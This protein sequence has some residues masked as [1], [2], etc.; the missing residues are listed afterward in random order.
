MKFT[1][2]LNSTI[3]FVIIL[4]SFFT[5]NSCFTG[6]FTEETPNGTDISGLP[7]KYFICDSLDVTP[8][9][10]TLTWKPKENDSVLI[11]LSGG[12]CSMVEMESGWLKDEVIQMNVDAKQAAGFS[13]VMMFGLSSSQE[14]RFHCNFSLEGKHLLDHD[15]IVYKKEG[16]AI[17]KRLV[18][19]YLPIHKIH[20]FRSLCDK[21]KL[22]WDHPIADMFISPEY[23]D[24]LETEK[25][26]DIT[27]YFTLSLESCNAN[28]SFFD[29]S[30][31]TKVGN[32]VTARANDFRKYQVVL[33]EPYNLEIDDTIF[34]LVETDD[35]ISK[36]KMVVAGTCAIN[37]TIKNIIVKFDKN[38]INDGDTLSA[39]IYHTDKNGNCVRF[40][41]TTR[42]EAGIMIGCNF[43]DIL[44]PNG[45]LKKYFNNIRQPI[46]IVAMDP[47]PK[48]ETNLRLRVGLIP[49]WENPY[50]PDN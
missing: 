37:D 50:N 48:G 31:N 11:E 2:K 45:Q 47:I 18:R 8:V 17:A 5:L 6:M 42:F 4:I 12:I 35:F 36:H 29:K 16:E 21:I 1:R 49:D 46:K 20:K 33:N 39:Y 40:A 10:F 30:L 25:A 14:Y 43:A 38:S 19:V 3:F 9:V 41:D 7:E 24:S 27:N 15:G 32:Q 26:Y 44:G 34:V 13:A 28:V 22:C 23:V